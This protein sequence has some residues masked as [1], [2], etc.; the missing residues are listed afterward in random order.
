M[1]KHGKKYAEAL[2]RVDR[3][4]EYTPGQ[5]IS[6]V[7]EIKSSKFDE[8]VEIHVRSGLNVRHAY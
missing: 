6:L 1:A 8:T 5:A 7:K 2:N 4:R 3:T